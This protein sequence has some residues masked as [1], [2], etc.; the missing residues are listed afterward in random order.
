MRWLGPFLLAIVTLASPAA[1]EIVTISPVGYSAEFA[2][3]LHDDLGER[4]G[5][6]LQRTVDRALRAALAREGADFGPS[7]P[8]T[9]E[10]VISDARANRPTFAQLSARPGLSYSGSLSTGGA[11]L[12]AVLRAADG[13]ELARVD[14][15]FY[16]GQ[17]EWAS[18]DDWGDARRAINQFAR[19]VALRYR[20]LAAN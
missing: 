20:A 16:E 5:P 13:R 1:A 10:T 2:A 19:E 9:V 11:A 8:I 18:L 17:L 7:G 3:K 15:H 6:I 12:T 14:H 4:E